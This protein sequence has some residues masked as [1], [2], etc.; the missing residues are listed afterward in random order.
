MLQN[1]VIIAGFG[2]P[3][4]AIADVL[5]AR[6]IPYCIIERNEI[7]TSQCVKTGVDIVTG[8]ARNE[9]CLRQA[10][11]ERA[12]LMAVAIPN[13]EVMLEVVA[14]AR[15]IAPEIPI[16]ARCVFTSA[17]FRAM[18]EGAEQ[19]VVAEQVVAREFARLIKE[20]YAPPEPPD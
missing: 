15:R 18:R 13:D 17:G 12:Q 20:R 4:R 2:L 16:I 11:I 9:D 8:D 3:G 14:A 5:H 19:I 7:T 6:E 10:G 1:H